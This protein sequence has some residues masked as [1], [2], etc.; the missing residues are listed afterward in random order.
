M[1]LLAAERMGAAPAR[2]VVIEDSVNGVLAGRAA[3]MTVFGFA[4]FTTAAKL[5]A[6]GADVAFSAMRELP[7]LLA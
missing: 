6:A 2:T 7:A 3:G 4:G 1:F 5:L